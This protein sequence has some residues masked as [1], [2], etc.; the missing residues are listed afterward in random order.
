MK[1]FLAQI[2]PIVGDLRTNFEKHVDIINIVNS[3]KDSNPKLIIFP[4]L[5][6]IGYPARDLLFKKE[7]LIRQGD[8]LKQLSELCPANL[9]ILVGGVSSNDTTGKELFNS[10]FFITWN[11]VADVFRKTLLPNYDVFDETRYFESNK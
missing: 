10:V 11:K 4:E 1:A 9:G 8:Y 2:N 7:L 5:S 3:K 6:L